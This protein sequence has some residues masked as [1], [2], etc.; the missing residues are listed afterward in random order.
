MFLLVLFGFVL[1]VYISS[2]FDC[3]SIEVFS[4]WLV[5]LLAS[6]DSYGFWVLGAN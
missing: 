5:S 2:M 4:L 3:L 6:L 1:W